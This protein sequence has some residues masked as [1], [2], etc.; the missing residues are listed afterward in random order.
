MKYD[1]ATHTYTHKG[2]VVPS[3]TQ[4]LK[5]AGVA[6][7]T[8]VSPEA[9]KRG[10]DVHAEIALSI[11]NGVPSID[12]YAIQ[13]W[14][15]IDNCCDTFTLSEQ[16]IFDKAI[17]VAGRIDLVTRINGKVWLI[18]WKLNSVYKSTG[19]QLAAYKHIWN[20]TR[21]PKIVHV[22]AVL[23]T[24]DSYQLC[25]AKGPHWP[26]DHRDDWHTFKSALERFKNG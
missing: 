12:K 5:H 14:D 26:T 20:A 10:S 25:D 24:P 9:L 22:G 23:L 15:F 16:I 2:K 17:M 1:D 4:I 21:K 18:D 7:H 19:P 6:D 3:V 11:E 13:A 8:F